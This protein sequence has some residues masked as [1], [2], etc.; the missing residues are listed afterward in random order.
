M[1]CSAERHLKLQDNFSFADVSE[2]TISEMIREVAHRGCEAIAVVCTNMRGAGNVEALEAELGM[3]V[4]DSIATTL[5]KSLLTA[6]ADPSR[7]KGWGSLFS[8]SLPHRRSQ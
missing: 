7:I 3:P 5:W 4:Y 6:G 1:S 2:N 8:G